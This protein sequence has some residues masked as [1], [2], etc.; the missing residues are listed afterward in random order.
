MSKITGRCKC[1]IL[2][3]FEHHKDIEEYQCPKC[4]RKFKRY[5]D[6][7]TDLYTWD[8]VIDEGWQV[9]ISETSQVKS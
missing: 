4:K 1:G 9:I 2:L 8:E 6:A 7:E 5:F 3:K